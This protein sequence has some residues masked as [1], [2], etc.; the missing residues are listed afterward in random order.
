[1][2]RVFRTTQK[3]DVKIYF[4][5]YNNTASSDMWDKINDKTKV[6]DNVVVRS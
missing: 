3:D 2:D 1:M 4:Q 5:I 6:I